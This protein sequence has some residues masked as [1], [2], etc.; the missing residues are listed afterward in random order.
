MG[1]GPEPAT[2]RAAGKKQCPRCHA[3]I[4]P[5]AATCSECKEPIQPREKPAK[6]AASPKA[7][8]NG[9]AATASI[10]PLIRAATAYGSLNEAIELLQAIS[11]VK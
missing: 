1:A 11:A 6:T 3:A 4:G 5:S 2:K 9:P 7:Q 8:A 10:V